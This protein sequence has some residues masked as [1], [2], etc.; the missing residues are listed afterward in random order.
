M[1]NF[2]STIAP[3][4]NQVK[5]TCFLALGYTM[6]WMTEN[7]P[8][9]ITVSF[10]F[11]LWLLLLVTHSAVFHPHFMGFSLHLIH[12]LHATV[13][14]QFLQI[15]SRAEIDMCNVE[16]GIGKH[17]SGK[18]LTS[19]CCYLYLHSLWLHGHKTWLAYSYRHLPTTPIKESDSD[20]ERFDPV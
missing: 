19:Q 8:N 14:W 4:V 10:F 5:L 3:G 12:V 17:L 1:D 13:I 7:L 18:P 15:H 2:F 16:P 9:L 6:T 11:L 20:W